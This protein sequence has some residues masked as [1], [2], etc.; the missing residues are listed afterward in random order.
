MT[1]RDRPADGARERPLLRLATAGSVDD[2]KST[3]IGRLLFD[4]KQTF[5]DQMAAI[6]RTSRDRGSDYVELALLTD[7]LR[8]ERQQ[9]ITID[10]AYRYFQTPRRKFI[11][12]DTP[13]HVQYTRNMVT[14]AST[15]DCALILVD[16]RRGVLE[17]TRRHAYLSAL[18][19]IRHF[20]LCVNKMDLVGFDEAVF[21]PAAAELSRFVSRMAGLASAADAPQIDVRAVPISAKDGDNVVEPS[22]KTPWYAG[23]PL[24]ELLETI[25]VADPPEVTARFPVQ[26]VIRPRRESHRDYRG[27][28]GTVAGGRLRVGDEVVVLPAGHRTTISA[29][30][31]CDGERSEAAAGE[32]ISLRLDGEFDIARGDMIASADSPPRSAGEISA[33]VCWMS[34]R[35]ALSAGGRLRIKHSTRATRALVDEV[36]ARLDVNT[37]E[38]DLTAQRLE[39]NDIGRVRLRLMS[40]LVVDP[41]EA[42]RAT[43]A[44]I[45]IDEA[46]RATVGAGMVN[47][48]A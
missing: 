22:A 47:S 33:H 34:E 20:V 14:G 30:D 36:T 12:A 13:G 10:V 16:A 24:L 26:Y 7:G 44:F 45:L 21:R 43:G 25:D 11:L 46:S 15:A 9:G 32:A 19:G 1:E 42:N 28:A 5:I 41:Y 35:S 6:E 2:G 23:P 17:Q 4:S 3:L 8:S 38:Y 40:P 37:L 27:Y 29:I 18:L 39:L 31:A 48:S